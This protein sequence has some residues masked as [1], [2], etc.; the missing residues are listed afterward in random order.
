[1]KHISR[2][3]A[4][5]ESAQEPRFAYPD[6]RDRNLFAYHTSNPMFRDSIDRDGLI[7]QG[8]SENWLEGTKIEGKALFATFSEDPSDWVN[9][10]YDDDVW[11]IDL[12]KIDNVWNVDPNYSTSSRSSSAGYNNSEKYMW[13]AQPIPREAI[14]LVHKGTGE[15]YT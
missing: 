3:S 1:M 10:D 15:E 14:E 7:P 2:F 9:W 12:S 5:L 4:F 13:T 11:R 8:K 6:G